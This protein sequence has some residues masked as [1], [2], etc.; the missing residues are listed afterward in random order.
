[1]DA[2]MSR[3]IHSVLVDYDFA[4]VKRSALA[5]AGFDIGAGFELRGNAG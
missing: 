5:I 1:M 4:A 2:R 3:A